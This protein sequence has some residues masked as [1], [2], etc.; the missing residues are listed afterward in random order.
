MGEGVGEGVGVEVD[1]GEGMGVAATGWAGAAGW[2]AVTISTTNSKP[3]TLS[4]TF[5]LMEFDQQAD[6]WSNRMVEMA[7]IEP[8]SERFDHGTLRA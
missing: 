8:A 1:V 2:H 6:C 3:Y 4:F 5:V 7:G